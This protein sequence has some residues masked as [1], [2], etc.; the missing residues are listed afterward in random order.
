MITT[1]ELSESTLLHRGS[2]APEAVRK[3]FGAKRRREIVR[4]RRESVAPF[5][6]RT[7]P[8]CPTQIRL[9]T[10][11]VDPV[12]GRTWFK[13]NGARRMRRSAAA[14]EVPN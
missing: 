14:G 11:P 13:G 8:L 10:P 9:F 7:A 3:S 1:N 4:Y 6:E 12:K 5:D 2:E